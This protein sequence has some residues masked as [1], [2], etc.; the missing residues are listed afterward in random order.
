MASA[1]RSDRPFKGRGAIHPAARHR[2]PRLRLVE[3]HD[4]DGSVHHV[5]CGLDAV[6]PQG[7][8]DGGVLVPLVIQ[9]LLDAEPLERGQ[10]ATATACRRSTSRGGLASIV[11]P[12][13]RRTGR[14]T[15]TRTSEGTARRLASRGRT[16]RGLIDL[17]LASHKEA[18]LLLL[19]VF[20]FLV[21][22]KLCAPAARMS[23]AAQ[24]SPDVALLGLSSTRERIAT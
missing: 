7:L 2:H 20:I 5:E 4:C 21:E 17:R 16:T 8:A 12:T 1:A 11:R 13:G 19:L 15:S 9:M 10:C 6:V 18:L 14:R 22:R 23:L 24:L 3:A